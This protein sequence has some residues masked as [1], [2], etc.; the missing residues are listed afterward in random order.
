L[1]LLRL[2]DPS[3]KFPLVAGTCNQVKLLLRAVVHG[4]TNR[5]IIDPVG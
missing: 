2:D 5:R 4:V 1:A 3:D